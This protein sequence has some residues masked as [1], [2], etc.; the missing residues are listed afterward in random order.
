ML[1]ISH[2]DRVLAYMRPGEQRKDDIIVLLNY[3]PGAVHVA[4]AGSA[5]K[6]TT[7]FADLVSRDAIPVASAALAIDVPGWGARVLRRGTGNAAR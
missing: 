3:S 7:S 2:P 5:F 4:L 6:D 1:E